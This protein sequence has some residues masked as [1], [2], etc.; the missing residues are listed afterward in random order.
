MSPGASVRTEPETVRALEL[1]DFLLIAEAVLEVPAKRIAEESSLHLADSALHAPL[2]C[3]G[4]EDFYPRFAEKAAVLCAHLVKNHPLKDGNA[5]VALIATIE[6]C[7]RNG[8]P[9]TPPPGDE[10]GEV[11]ASRLLD[12]AGS[13]LTDAA[14]ADLA[15]WID[16][17]IEPVGSRRMSPRPPDSP[18]NDS[19]GASPSSPAR[20]RAS[21]GRSPSPWPSGAPPS[22]AW[23]GARTCSTSSHPSWPGG[24]QRSTT[25][26]CDV[27]DADAFAAA[28]DAVEDE[29]G[30][31]DILVNNAG[32]DLMLPVP[33]GDLGTVREVFDVNFFATV[34]GTLA[35]V[36]GMVE[37]GW[38]VVVNVSSDTA[39][40][41]EP[42]QGA[43]AASKAAISAFSE[44]VAHEV[45]ARGVHVHVLYPG[46]VPTAMGLSG[47]ED[48]GS[49]PPKMVRRT[50][51]QVATLVAD[52]MGG[53]HL[54]INAA[55]LPLLAPIARTLAPL[56]YQKAMRRMAT[57]QG[58]HRG[59]PPL[60]SR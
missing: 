47:N 8:H 7:Q 33:G 10:D 20:R 53:P 6:F 48:G 29:H 19:T 39:R 22:S 15:D 56:T 3:F 31:I 42:K 54:D 24:P 52:R 40:A 34:A 44:S 28:L 16:R 23:P 12:V 11:T 45:A 50:E 13:P 21:A 18:P 43:Y 38:G 4:G 36:P 59:P 1:A 55:R 5:P 58:A 27:G 26:V 37:R 30:H 2:A 32:V 60:R 41:P 9:W 35:V 46:W 14:V 57:T 25:A 17:R 51:Q 49:L